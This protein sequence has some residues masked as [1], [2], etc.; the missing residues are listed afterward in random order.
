MK[1]IQNRIT[2]IDFLRGVA[3]ILMVVFHLAYDLNEFYNYDIDYQKGLVDYIGEISALMFITITGI[4]C[5]F[6]RNNLKRGLK[7]LFYA[8]LITLFTYIYDPATYI[9]F[10]ILHLLGTCILLYP[11]FKELKI[12]TLLVLSIINISLGNIFSKLTLDHN[13]LFPLGLTSS[14]YSALDYYPLFPYLGV[15]LLGMAIKK[16]FYQQKRSLLPISLPPNPLN[17]ISKHSLLI[18]LIHQPI[19]LWIL[20]IFHTYF[21]Q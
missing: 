15:F 7:V 3:I 4:S 17:F 9:N 2:E 6:S 14:N 20:F 11:L 8:F 19:I 5:S 1:Y 12:S 18:Y 21:Y 10:G 13:Y 16:I